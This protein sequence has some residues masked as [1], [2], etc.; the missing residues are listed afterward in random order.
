MPSGKDLKALQVEWDSGAELLP[1]ESRCRT[2]GL[3]SSDCGVM[4]LDTVRKGFC[5]PGRSVQA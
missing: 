5:L 1:E 2:R 3:A 4:F